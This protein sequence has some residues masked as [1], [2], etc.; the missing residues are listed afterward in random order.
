MDE[1]ILNDETMKELTGET[2]NEYNLN[3]DDS[4][5]ILDVCC[6]GREFWYNKNHKNTIY[7]DKRIAEKGHLPRRKN[8]E[9]KPDVVADFKDIP[10]GDKRFKLVVFDP[11]HLI[12]GETSVMRKQYGGLYKNNWKEEIKGGFDECWRVLKDYGILIFKWN[13]YNIKK[14]EVLKLIGREPLFGHPTNRSTSNTHWLCFMKIPN[15]V[16]VGVSE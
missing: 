14:S 6:S 4:K 15:D 2:D 9:V 12:L 3:C 10:F 7:M 1:E 8:H 13:Q 5:F 11:P 16:L